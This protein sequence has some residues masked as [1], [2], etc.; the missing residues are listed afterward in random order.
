[1]THFAFA[2]L[3]DLHLLPPGETLYGRDPAVHLRAAIDASAIQATS[4][5]GVYPGP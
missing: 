5:T 4:L 2:Q 1:M 3:T